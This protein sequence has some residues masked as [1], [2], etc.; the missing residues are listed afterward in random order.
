[1]KNKRG[2]FYLIASIVI[3][4]MFLGT[5][6]IRNSIDR[7]VTFNIDHLESELK[8]EI[9]KTLDYLTFVGATKEESYDAFSN[10]SEVFINKETKNKDFIFIFGEI[11]DITIMG[12]N[13]N[14]STIEYGSGESYVEINDIE[15]FKIQNINVNDIKIKANDVEYS[16]NLNNGQNIYYWVRYP[17]NNEVYVMHG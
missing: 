5:I 3:I 4:S 15:S 11:G 16:F 17:Y 14:F 12:Y 6:A 9:K 7:Q 13:S 10:L 1:M 2:Q 8:T